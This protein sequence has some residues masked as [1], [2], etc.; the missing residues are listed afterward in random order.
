MA[1]LWEKDV[2]FWF[3]TEQCE[4]KNWIEEKQETKSNKEVCSSTRGL[5]ST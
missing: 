3:E 5:Q 2:V 1:T 4:L